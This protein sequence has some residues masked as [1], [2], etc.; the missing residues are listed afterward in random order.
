MPPRPVYSDLE[1]EISAQRL[2]GLVR[3]LPHPVALAGGHAVRWTVGK[4]WRERFGGDYFGSRDIDLAYFVDPAWNEDAF[5][6]S[7]AG[8][9]PERI[10]AMHYEPHGMYRFRLLVDA[11]GEVIQE[12]PGPPAIAGVD[13]AQLI[14]D[15]LMTA[16]H[17]KAKQVLGWRPIVEPLLAHAF[18]DPHR[19]RELTELGSDVYLPS[20]G[21]LIATKL[22]H[23]EER[24]GD[25]ALKDLCDIYALVA[26]GGADT[27]TVVQEIHDVLPDV[28]RRV[29]LAINHELLPE[30]CDHLDIGAQDF[31]AIVGPLAIHRAR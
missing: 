31:R 28:P 23:L 1:T 30:A 24:A 15:P 11:S 8:Q 16:D 6:A 13:Y 5:R 19:R 14:L 29:Q 4:A 25:K 27:S 22:G 12:E 10:K 21:S 20:P 17:P 2:E 7:A 18:H 26:Y 9:A 3:D